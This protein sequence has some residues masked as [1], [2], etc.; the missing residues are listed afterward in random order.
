MKKYCLILVLA[1]GL[2]A[3]EQEPPIEPTVEVEKQEPPEEPK[4]EVEKEKLRDVP[5]PDFPTLLALSAKAASG[6]YKK[7]YEEETDKLSFIENHLDLPKKL[8]LSL[9]GR[10]L[11]N[12]PYQMNTFK[13]HS[14]EINAFSLHPTKPLIASGGDD[15]KL[16]IT[17]LQTGTIIDTYSLKNDRVLSVAYNPQGDKILITT[18]QF[19]GVY[20]T[21]RKRCQQLNCRSLIRSAQFNLDGSLIRA[22]TENGSTEVW[23]STTGV[24]QAA[25]YL[26]AH[27]DDHVIFQIKLHPAGSGFA[28]ASSD[29][30][31]KLWKNN[32]QLMRKL[33]H[34]DLVRVIEPSPDG[35]FWMTADDSGQVKVWDA[36][37]G[38]LLNKKN[39]KVHS[40]WI[41]DIAFNEH[42]DVAV[43]AS[44]DKTLSVWNRGKFMRKLQGHKSGVLAVDVNKLGDLTVSGAKDGKIAVWNPKSGDMLILFAAHKGN[45]MDIAFVNSDKEVVSG[46]ADGALRQW[47]LMDESYVN[48]LT[49]KQGL[50]LHHL[51]EQ[52]KPVRLPEGLHKEFQGLPKDLQKLIF[53]EQK[54]ID[55]NNNNDS[56][57]AS[58]FKSKK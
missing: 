50:L 5:D 8:T 56:G 51:F 3:M 29:Y 44:D 38:S 43:V 16:V 6:P 58:W 48:T 18:D 30:T 36:A 1:A 53:D 15:G 14:D 52:Q 20:D 49:P 28:T 42:G 33:D 19:T 23:D 7:I 37:D 57:M 22:G 2:N 17:D 31:A 46:G 9:L 21:I 39:S 11:I 24:A 54:A 34:E 26:R 47:K 45:V 32:G 25:S 27:C 10:N 55:S 4:I 13:H 35:T 41:R 40:D 12:R